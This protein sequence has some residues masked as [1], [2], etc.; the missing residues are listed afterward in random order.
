MIRSIRNRE[1]KALQIAQDNNLAIMGTGD[2][3]GLID[4]EH[5]VPHGHRPI[6]LVFAKSATAEAI[7]EGFDNRRTVALH[8]NLLIGRDEFLVPLVEA[9]LTINT[10]YYADKPDVLTLVIKTGQAYNLRCKTGA[11]IPCTNIQTW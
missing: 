2:I 10:A 5:N 6:T 11:A 3:H 9:S 1:I 7:H 8:N 4:W